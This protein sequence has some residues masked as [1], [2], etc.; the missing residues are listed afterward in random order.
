MG[1]ASIFLPVWV[2]F[3]RVAGPVVVR[4]KGTF[5]LGNP[6]VTGFSPTILNLMRLLNITCV[7]FVGLTGAIGVMGV[8]R[9]LDWEESGWSLA[10]SPDTV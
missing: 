1:V 3:G 5:A 7:L 4:Q 2:G 8:G 9:R 10:L 6:G